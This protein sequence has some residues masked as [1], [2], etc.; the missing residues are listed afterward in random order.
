MSERFGPCRTCKGR[1]VVIAAT[2]TRDPVLLRPE[3]KEQE[4]GTCEG[5]GHSGHVEDCP[6]LQPED[7]NR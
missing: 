6:W 1:G 3:Y 5:T 4:C 7:E 2:G